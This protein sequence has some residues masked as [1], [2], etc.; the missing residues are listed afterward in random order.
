MTSVQLEWVFFPLFPFI[1]FFGGVVDAIQ[2]KSLREYDRGA[3]LNTVDFSGPTRRGAGCG[4]LTLSLTTA[5]ESL[6][7]KWI[8]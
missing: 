3:G 1:S 7:L 4:E 2:R 8:S 6:D 5:P